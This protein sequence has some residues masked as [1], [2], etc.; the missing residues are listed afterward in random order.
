MRVLHRLVF[1]V[2]A[3]AGAAGCK[4]GLGDRCQ[5]DSDCESGHCSMG[6]NPVCTNG[7]TTGPTIDAPPPS[8]ARVDGGSLFPD[9]RLPDAAPVPDGPPPIPDA[10]P[11]APDAPLPDAG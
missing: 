7:A 1:V 9:A 10:P 5:I 4:Q 2:A 6:T 8:D 11:A 3:L